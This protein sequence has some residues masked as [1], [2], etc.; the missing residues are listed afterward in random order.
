M[1]KNSAE[2]KKRLIEQWKESGKSRWTF[3]KEQGIGAQTLYKWT[4]SAKE[5]S[6]F[7]ELRTGNKPVFLNNREMILERGETRIR[8]PL[9]MSEREMNAVT[10][11]WKR[12][13]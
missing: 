2:E 5:P 1:K 9:E 11:L 10:T 13:V 6:G 8:I 12:L 4:A 7:V 3:A